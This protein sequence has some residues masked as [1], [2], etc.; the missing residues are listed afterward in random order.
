[1]QS[2][3]KHSRS[4]VGAETDFQFGRRS[5]SW[6]AGASQ[7]CKHVAIPVLEVTPVRAERNRGYVCK[8]EWHDPGNIKGAA[9]LKATASGNAGINKIAGH[10]TETF[11]APATTAISVIVA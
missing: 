9:V 10:S 1:V 7:R 11:I 2:A 5:I 6:S 4:R 8:R 3:W